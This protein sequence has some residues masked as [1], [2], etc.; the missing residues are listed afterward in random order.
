[1]KP[2]AFIV[3]LML[4]AG[5]S[6]CVSDS[7]NPEVEENTQRYTFTADTLNR[8]ADGGASFN[9]AENLQDGPM[10]VLWVSTGCHGCH[11]WTDALYAAAE[12]GTLSNDSIVTIHRY[13]DF[14]SRQSLHNVY[15]SQNNSTHPTSWPVVIPDDDTPVFDMDTQS[16]VVGKTVFEAFDYPL[17]PTLQIFNTHG[18]I[19]WTSDE[20]RPTQFSLNNVV[21]ILQ[22]VDDANTLD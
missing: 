9:L 8:S 12:N 20:Y 5:L 15:G 3:L 2:S 19:V 17:S 14:E 10:I 13:P 21:E 11:D 22:G 7:T 1:M 18:D 4:C 6:G 16:L